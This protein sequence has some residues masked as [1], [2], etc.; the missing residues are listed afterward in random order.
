MRSF[1]RM[2]FFFAITQ[3]SSRRSS[4][5]SARPKKVWFTTISGKNAWHAQEERSR[6]RFG[7]GGA[8]GRMLL[9]RCVVRGSGSAA[10]ERPERMRTMRSSSPPRPAKYISD[11]SVCGLVVRLPSAV[12]VGTQNSQSLAKSAI[13][14][15]QR[16][17]SRYVASRLRSSTPGAS[18]SNS[19]LMNS[20]RSWIGRPSRHAGF[21][22]PHP[23]PQRR[24]R[25]ELGVLGAVAF[26]A[27]NGME[28][29]LARFLV[30]PALQHAD[31]AR[32]A[33]QIIDAGR[34]EADL[35]IR[36][37]GHV[38]GRRIAAGIDE[39]LELAKPR[40][41][42]MRRL[43]D[44]PDHGAAQLGHVDRDRTEGPENR[45]DLI[46]DLQV[47]EEHRIAHLDHPIGLQRAD[48]GADLVD[49]GVD[50]AP[51]G[52]GD[53]VPD[54][55][56]AARKLISA[57]LHGVALAPILLVRD[58]V[59]L[60]FAA[61]FGDRHEAAMGGVD[62]IGVLPVLEL[63]LPV[64]AI[65]VGNAAGDDLHALRALLH[66]QVDEEFEIA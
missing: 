45:H 21:H 32:I 11:S 66:M 55:A 24:M 33:L 63:H 31:A 26:D 64:A 43:A 15:S 27:G 36:E 51:L 62:V 1:S 28:R 30:R 53:L 17:S 39:I 35:A 34:A 44:R 3:P 50:G 40:R 41:A 65:G 47:R 22:Q 14:S 10:G 37:D 9:T 29:R 61:P 19:A 16:R 54:R 46:G 38:V 48:T 57:D 4:S 59:A 2:V 8:S 18:S 25:A 5:Y 42:Q 12:Q 49:R 7:S 13:H 56:V 52:L 23:F 60:A 58:D 6:S 20:L